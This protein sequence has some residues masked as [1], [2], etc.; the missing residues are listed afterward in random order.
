MSIHDLSACIAESIAKKLASERE[1]GR[2]SEDC[3]SLDLAGLI[4]GEE[5]SRIDFVCDKASRDCLVAHVS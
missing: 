1:S 2:I 4:G 5:G 3:V